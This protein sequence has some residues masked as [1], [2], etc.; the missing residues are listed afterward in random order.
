MEKI[1]YEVGS[2][3]L[4]VLVETIS[5]FAKAFSFL[6]SLASDPLFSTIVALYSLILL[7]LPRIFVDL[8]FSPVLISTAVL[9][10]SLLRLG[11]IQSVEEQ[12]KKKPTEKEE[13]EIEIELLPVEVHKVVKYETGTETEEEAITEAC[14]SPSLKPFFSAFNSFVEWNVG[15]PLEVIY[16]EYEGEE[17]E[18]EESCQM[19]IDRIPSLSLYYPES[20]S[21]SSSDGD[22][23]AIGKWDSRESMCFRW[24]EEDRE[25][26]IE[27]PLDGK[28]NSSSVLQVEEENLIEIDISLAPFGE[29]QRGTDFSGENQ[30]SDSV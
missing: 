24:D 25:G 3:A 5:F 26:L 29:L 23:P 30:N 10:S 22:F 15:A 16:E 9:L 21:D 7:Y 12:I 20:E 2:L 11:A 19:G 4:N 13:I 1:G 14:F 18:K 27:I 6:S 28:R 8:V 17:E